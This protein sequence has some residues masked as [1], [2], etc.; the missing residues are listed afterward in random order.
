M[1]CKNSDNPSVNL[2]IFMKNIK[3]G[4]GNFFYHFSWWLKLDLLVELCKLKCNKIAEFTTELPI[5]QFG[6]YEIISLY[7]TVSIRFTNNLT[8]KS[9]LKPQKKN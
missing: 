7:A 1:A 8:N 5:I 6:A 9:H 3:K 2:K 4:K